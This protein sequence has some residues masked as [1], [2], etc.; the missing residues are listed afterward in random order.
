[1]DTALGADSRFV[2][3][4]SI[5]LL[6]RAGALLSVVKLMGDARVLVLGF[7]MQD[8]V[9]VTIIRMIV[10]DPETAETLFIEKG[11][12]YS[13]IEVLVVQMPEGPL[14]LSRCLTACLA[15]ETN[16]HIAYPLLINPN[17]HSAL[18]LHLEDPEVGAVIMETH[19]FIILKQADLSR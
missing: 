17:G 14:T 16:I 6:N 7:S 9:D 11:I 12:P 19:G 4:F 2:R 3:Q 18:A 5:F 1:M 8:S 10:S 13:V 15:G